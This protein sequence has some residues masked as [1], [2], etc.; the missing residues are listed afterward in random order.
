MLELNVAS[1]KI[2]MS[3]GL[4]FIDCKISKKLHIFIGLLDLMIF[5][6]KV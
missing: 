3:N 6:K 5:L 4:K 2:V 1:A